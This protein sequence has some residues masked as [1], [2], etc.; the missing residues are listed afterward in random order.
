[1]FTAEKRKELKERLSLFSNSE[2]YTVR[3][4]GVAEGVQDG[5]KVKKA[6]RYAFF[7]QNAAGGQS[8]M[9]A[10]SQETYEQHATEIEEILAEV[11]KERVEKEQKS[12]LP[13]AVIEVTHDYETGISYYSFNQRLSDADWKKVAR[14]MT[15]YEVEDE[16]MCIGPARGWCIKPNCIAD[17][18]DT[19]NIAHGL[20]ERKNK[21]PVDDTTARRKDL[22]RKL[23]EV[24]QSAEKPADCTEV[25]GVARLLDSSN[26]HGSG[27]W[28]HLTDTHIWQVINNG[29]AGDDWSLNN[30]KTAGAGAIA[31][32]IP[33]TADLAELVEELKSLDSEV[34]Q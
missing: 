21:Q 20:P 14:Y 16:S 15:R 27:S 32:R 1:M 31:Y 26:A 28:Y 19:L 23:E 6:Y 2:Y 12:R 13:L 5:K 34:K 7:S 17:V 25:E 11:K 10:I 9:F 8:L 3:E 33:R 22:E 29:M 4:N 24:F 30:Y 18:L